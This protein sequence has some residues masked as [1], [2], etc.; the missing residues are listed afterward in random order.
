[1]RRPIDVVQLLEVRPRLRIGTAARIAGSAQYKRMGFIEEDAR[2]ELG[3]SWPHFR[4]ADPPE[5]PVMFGHL[6]LVM[7]RVEAS[8]PKGEF[9]RANPTAISARRRHGI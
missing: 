6:V 7:I 3:A 8:L 5:A 1:M 4:E 2:A 9:V